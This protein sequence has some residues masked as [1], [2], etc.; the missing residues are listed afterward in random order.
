MSYSTFHLEY[1]LVLSRFCL[2]SNI[3][4]ILSRYSMYFI[5][6]THIFEG[7]SIDAFSKVVFANLNAFIKSEIIVLENAVILFPN[8]RFWLIV[9]KFSFNLQA[10]K[11]KVTK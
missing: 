6:V 2:A 7:H 4:E 5:F 3:L 10:D 8:G 1:P 11:R 9:Y